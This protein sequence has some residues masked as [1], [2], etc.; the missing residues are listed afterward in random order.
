MLNSQNTTEEAILA[1][2]TRSTPARVVVLRVTTVHS[3]Q[4]QAQR[5]FASRQQNQVYMIAHQAP[6]PYRHVC[7]AQVLAQQTQIGVAI[8]IER[9]RR[10]PVC[11]TLGD[12]IRNSGKNTTR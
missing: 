11:S 12:V 3:T 7:V 4:Q 9:K 6:R 5:I 8:F 2:V 10:L 1:R